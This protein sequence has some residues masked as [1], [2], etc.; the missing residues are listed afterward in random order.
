MREENSLFEKLFPRFGWSRHDYYVHSHPELFGKKEEDNFA[1]IPLLIKAGISAA[2]AIGGYL[3]SKEEENVDPELIKAG[4]QCIPTVISFIYN[5]W[6]SRKKEEEDNFAWIPLLI[7]AGISAAGA[8]GGYL[9][10]KEEDNFAWAALIPYIPAVVG[11][12]AKIGSALLSKEEDNFAFAALVPY[13]PSIIGAVGSIAAG[14]IKHF[15]K[16]EENFSFLP[17]VAG[18]LIAKKFFKKEEENGLWAKIKEK[19]DFIGRAQRA[20]QE[21]I[22]RIWAE[23]GL[24]ENG[25]LDIIAKIKDYIP[26][27]LSLFF[28]KAQEPVEEEPVAEEPVVEAEPEENWLPLAFAIGTSLFKIGKAIF[29]E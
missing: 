23:A 12:V 8:L 14:A 2:G 9:L 11:A 6:S 17:L 15:K 19:L 18:A 29:S 13:I 3:L 4:I 1:W 24:E 20:R 5:V 25:L 22:D 16:D 7:K 26:F 28:P 10:S 21:Q 27:L